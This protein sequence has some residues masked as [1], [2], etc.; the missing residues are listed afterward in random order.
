LSGEF[1][2]GNRMKVEIWSDIACPWCYIGR[3]RFEKALHQFEHQDQV[4]VIWR[5][6]ELDPSAPRDFTGSVNDMLMQHYGITREKA[7]NA[8]ERVIKLAAMEGLE[9][10][11]DL[12][13][14]VNSF[15]AHRLIH[16]AAKHNRQS[17]MKERLQKAYFT[18]GA[19]VSDP[20]TLI[21]LAGEVG[22]DQD[23]TRSMLEGDAF[24]AAV[25]KDESRARELGID[26]V[27][28]FFFDES[29][30]VYGAQ[31]VEV[32]TTALENAWTNRS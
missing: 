32:F 20:E 29:T 14:P 10:H 31:P 19:V 5:S 4:E 13:H 12:A 24:M 17:E 11:L 23:E 27:P 3:R 7:E 15:D 16:L 6:Y 26:G 30:S 21:R 28:F 18:E 25:Q 22:L 2:K 1:E 8:N 9:Y